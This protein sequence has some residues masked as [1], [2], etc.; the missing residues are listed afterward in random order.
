MLKRRSFWL[1]FALVSAACAVL[2]IRL[3]PLAFPFVSLDIRMDREHA[4]RAAHALA[5]SQQWGPAGELRDAASFGDDNSQAF[6]ELEGGG[7]PVF[8]ELLRDELYSPY[9]WHVRLF[10]ESEEHQVVVRFKPG[11][12]PYGFDEK[13]REQA[14]GAALAADTAREIAERTATSA[15]WNLP[16]ARF[17]AV[18]QSQIVRPGGRI[19]HTFVYERED[20]PLG[21]GR[22]RLQLVVS[23]D[24]LTS[25]AHFVK[26]PEAFSRR[27]EQM[28]SANNAI[29]GGASVVMLLVF[30]LGGGGVGAWYLMRQRAVLWRQPLVWAGIIGGLQLAAALN[31]WPLEWLRYD[32]ALSSGEFTTQRLLAAIT[33]ALLTTFVLFVSFLV[34]EGLSRRAFPHHPQLWKLWSRD[35]GPTVQALGRT[36]GGYLLASIAVVYVSVFYYFAFRKL[37]WWMPSEALVNPDSIA[38]LWPWLS[39]LARASHAGFWEEALF[40]AVPLAGA[41]LLGSRFGGRRWWIAGAFVL[42]AIVFSAAHANYPGMPAYSRLV[43]LLIP[44]A[45]FGAVFLRFGLY[46]AALLH[47]AYD[48]ALM[49]LPLFAASADGIWVDR[50]LVILLS[51]APLWIVLWRRWQAGGWREL[52]AGLHNGGWMPAAAPEAPRAVAP[53]SVSPGLSVRQRQTVLVFGLVGLAVWWFAFP[54]RQPEAPLRIDRAQAIAAARAELARRGIELPAGWRADAIVPERPAQADRFV[55]QT[56]GRDGYAALLGTYVPPLRWRVRFVSFT[57][58]VAERAEE[59]NVFLGGAG[60]VQRAQHR[61][62]E[63]RAGASLTETEARTR[64]HAALR[65]RWSIEPDSLTEVSATSA[66][67]PNR[68]D[69]TFIFKDPAVTSLAPGEA[70]LQVNLAGDEITD[71]TRFVFVPEAWERMDRARQSYFRI[72][73]VLKNITSAAIILAGI[74]GAIVAWSRQR[75]DVRTAMLVAG[76]VALTGIVATINRWPLIRAGFSTAQPLSLQQT[77]IIVGS[78]VGLLVSSAGLGLLAGLVVRWLRPGG[79]RGWP[80]LTTGCGLGAAVAGGL[81]LATLLRASAAPRW[82]SIGIAGTHASWLGSSTSAVSQLLMQTLTLLMVFAFIERWTAGWQRR[83][84]LGLAIVFSVVGVLLI[85]WGAI[86]VAHW[87]ALVFAGAAIMT[88]AYWLVLRHDLTLMPIVAG[89]MGAFGA[90]GNGLPRNYSGALADAAIAVVA[91]VGIGA[92]LAHDLRRTAAASG[93]PPV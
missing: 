75:F 85:P 44:S 66:K 68:T 51:L 59:W 50:S 45:I 13:L 33:G 86:S 25:L 9:R 35:A 7:K 43:E 27:F 93:N 64:A 14:P 10:K 32:T 8:R 67:R 38:H 28:R 65:E 12:E 71:W 1:L 69:W 63:A 77:M 29:A 90:L 82:P 6:V 73:G 3:F 83:R 76:V 21:E 24:R 39:P 22:L 80:A 47:F 23:G 57:G 16:L 5:T 4:I 58:D 36:L 20:R 31:A 41:A 88:A 49:A 72:G 60:D 11:G 15:P 34:A 62:P 79:L 52:P 61:L 92:W 18:E 89:A 19:D 48:V 54:L 17:T 37:G 87:I 84:A 91:V 70:R 78:S 42:Q 40:R 2:A 81:A 53:V 55:W 26:I 46:P 56:A 30:L 74:V